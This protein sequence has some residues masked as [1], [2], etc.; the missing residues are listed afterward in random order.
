MRVYIYMILI[1]GRLFF[2]MI[3]EESDFIY[4]FFFV[5]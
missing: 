4:N 5:R 2:G 1:Y 3:Y